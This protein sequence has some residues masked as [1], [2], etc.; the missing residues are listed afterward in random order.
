MKLIITPDYDELSRRGAALMADLIASKPDAAV[1]LA[2]GETPM[3]MYRELAAIRQRSGLDT[4]RLRVFQL[5]AY[6][7]LGP[8]DPRSLY[9]WMK[10]SFLDPMQIPDTNVVRLPGDA[11]DPRAVCA[12][13]EQAVEAAGGI[14]LSVLG[15]GPNGHL[16]FNE[17]PAEPRSPSRVIDL[18]E[19][20]IE[21][22]ARYWGGRDRVPRQA[23]TA[24]MSVLLASRH[25]LLVAS[26]E[27]KA[28][29]LQRALQ[30]P[31]TPQVPASYLQQAPR[32]TVIADQDAAALLRRY[33]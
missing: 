29:I 13:Y 9:G 16:G 21:S 31:V 19:E 32:L 30:G 12:A 10:R 28:G 5:D 23:L 33:S 27:R 6:L 22:N 25:V 18:T 20:S 15:L 14:D 26:G 3:G 24:G 8:D 7:G 11:P 1:I 17:P 4:S 2:T